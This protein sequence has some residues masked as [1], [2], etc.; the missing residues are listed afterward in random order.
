MEEVIYTQP[1]CPSTM[2]SVRKSPQTMTRLVSESPLSPWTA[3]PPCEW[4]PAVLAVMSEGALRMPSRRL[5]SGTGLPCQ[6][7][8]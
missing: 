2:R 6:D 1:N 8:L 4:F 7:V 5:L 3:G